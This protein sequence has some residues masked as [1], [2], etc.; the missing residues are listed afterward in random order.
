MNFPPLPIAAA[1]AL[2]DFSQYLTKGANAGDGVTLMIGDMYVW[3]LL[4]GGPLLIIAGLALMKIMFARVKFFALEYGNG[5]F[6]GRMKAIG[7]FI[8][9]GM[10][11]LLVGAAATFAGWLAQG[12]SATLTANGVTEVM[13]GETRRYAWV[14]AS[15]KAE[16]IKS[17][18]FWVAFSKDDH[19]CRLQF[20]QRYIGEKLQD[21]AIAITELG[22][23]TLPRR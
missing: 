16:H 5:G 22:I 10:L 11:L 19:R 2:P 20:Q 1:F 21:K 14:D 6:F 15:D 9:L 23:S 7:P 8:V 18:D 17:T 13:R 4:G 12:Y 3:G